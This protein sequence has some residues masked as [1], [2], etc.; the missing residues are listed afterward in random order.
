MRSLKKPCRP[1][2]WNTAFNMWMRF[3]VSN[4]I[5]DSKSTNILAT[6]KS[7]SGFDN[8][9]VILIA[10]VLIV[11]MNLMNCALLTTGLKEMVILG[12]SAPRVKRAADKAGVPFVDAAD[13]SGCDKESLWFVSNWDKSCAT[14]SCQC[15][16]G[17]VS[18]FWSA[19][20][21]IPCY[22]K[23][24]EIKWKK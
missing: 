23:R 8:S 12:E 4:S 15:Q 19:W 6:I 11:A 5:N 13:V 24:V 18:E 9:K 22:S 7:S 16:L 10:G 20:G 3:K 17:Y 21:W 2:V 14:K 1:L